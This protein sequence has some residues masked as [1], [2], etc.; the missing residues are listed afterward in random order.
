MPTRV[1]YWLAEEFPS[2]SRWSFLRSVTAGNPAPFF[3]IETRPRSEL[4]RKGKIKVHHVPSRAIS[5]APPSPLLAA[6]RLRSALAVRVSLGAIV[7]PWGS[8]WFSWILTIPYIHSHHKIKT[9]FTIC[10]SSKPR[11]HGHP[12]DV[13]PWFLHLHHSYFT[14]HVERR[15]WQ[16]HWKQNK[17]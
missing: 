3:N 17:C 11:D 15:T 8:R 14:L 5:H 2:Y 10:C 16:R 12:R 6:A 9:E 13:R 4:A 1:H 7:R